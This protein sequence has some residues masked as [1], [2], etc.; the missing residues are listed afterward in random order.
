[1]KQA[2]FSQ[3]KII[4]SVLLISILI[5]CFLILLMIG[6][7]TYPKI[8]RSSQPLVVVGQN[9]KI[10]QVIPLA[11]GRIRLP[12][13]P[14]D[15]ISSLYLIM[16][17]ASEDQ[18]FLEHH[19]VDYWAVFRAGWE[20]ISH[21]QFRSGASTLTMQLVKLIEPQKKS[22]FFKFLQ[23]VKA[24]KLEEVLSKEEILDDYLH[25]IPMGGR[26][27]GLR[28]G[29]L[30][31]FNREPVFLT[32]AQ[33]ALLITIPKNP[34]LYHP[35]RSPQ[36]CKKAR[37]LI[38]KHVYQKG[39]LTQDEY[40]KA[41]LEPLPH[42]IYPLPRDLAHFSADLLTSRKHEVFER[43][44]IDADQERLLANA[45]YA[46]TD[47]SSLIANYSSLQ[48]G[49]PSATEVEQRHLNEII[50]TT[51][52]ER[53]Q[54]YLNFKLKNSLEKETIKNYAV[55]AADLHT[56]HILSYVGSS[57]FYDQKIEGQ[58]DMTQSFRS[59]GSTLKPFL[60]GMAFDEGI[61]HPQTILVDQMTRLS[62]YAPSN[63][64]QNFMG[65]MK[66]WE[67]LM[68]SLNTPAIRLLAEIGVDVFLSRLKNQKLSIK[69]NGYPGL[70]L[71]LGGVS[72]R[73]WDLLRLY[74]SVCHSSGKSLNPVIFDHAVTK[75]VREFSFKSKAD[76]DQAQIEP[77]FGHNAK[78]WVPTI[79]RKL[80]RPYGYSNQI[81][82]S[83]KTGTSYDHR[84]AWAIGCDSQYVV[85]VWTGRADGKPVDQQSGLQDS[86]PMLF[87]VFKQLG[88][89]ESVGDTW[90]EA[91][92]RL[93]KFQNLSLSGDFFFKEERKKSFR[94]YFS[95]IY[96]WNTVSTEDKAKNIKPKAQKPWELE[97]H[98]RKDTYLQYLKEDQKIIN[99]KEDGKKS[100]EDPLLYLKQK[101][102]KTV[103]NAARS[104]FQI[105]YPAHRQEMIFEKVSKGILLR[106]EGGFRPIKWMINGRELEVSEEDYWSKEKLWVPPS[107]GFYEIAVFDH[108]NQYVSIDIEIKDPTQIPRA[109]LVG[110]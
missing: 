87:D 7:Y 62:Q 12:N 84:D 6:R 102:A 76:Q 71:I 22:L 17:K 100:K 74:G 66:A 110:E 25:L 8:Y 92:I 29:S 45:H 27:E 43:I 37:D 68:M 75:D 4:F 5:I 18:R 28:V 70:S 103:Q 81:N 32:P 78:A 34:N 13:Y 89:G 90:A 10:L 79:L 95:N 46:H 30:I 31:Y 23:M 2:F 40:E 39:I 94:E 61:L 11:D 41:I 69:H 56:G 99:Q 109:K 60:Y 80:P 82:V 3:K 104:D 58:N 88:G 47:Q 51:I 105:I 14:L 64:E 1:M 67:T 106:V 85:A 21:A 107:I 16:L 20:A 59:P 36:K 55:L 54:K 86:A 101:N 65:E 91:P 73:L 24:H 35:L 93:E 72:M 83:F 97:E 52:D 98:K 49:M 19:G 96:D 44:E 15:Q 50:S 26:Y 57:D 33:V 42:K 77:I 63:F 53:L 38:L 9:Q 108:K 48:E